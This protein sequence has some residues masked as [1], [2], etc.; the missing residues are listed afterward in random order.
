MPDGFGSVGVAVFMRGVVVRPGVIP[1]EIYITHHNTDELMTF[2]LL[3]GLGSVADATLVGVAHEPLHA[4]LAEY[5]R[6]SGGRLPSNHSQVF[7][8]IAQ[9]VVAAIF[10]HGFGTVAFADDVRAQGLP[11][12]ADRPVSW[13][14]LLRIRLFDGFSIEGINSAA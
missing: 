9:S 10:A 11:P 4:Q 8:V 7:P 6:I 12:P 3:T 5:L 14:W 2:N 1:D 13:P